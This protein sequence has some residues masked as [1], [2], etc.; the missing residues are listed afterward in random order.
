MAGKNIVIVTASIGSG[1]NKA[2][3]ALEESLK[4]NYPNSNVHI[5]DFVANDTGYI[6]TFVK[7]IYL[8]LLGYTPN[9]YDFFY[10]FTSST[11]RGKTV[12]SIFSICMKQEMKEIIKRYNADMIICTHPF[13]CGAANLLKASGQMD[14]PLIAII[15]D[16]A[17][18][19]F[20]YHKAVDLY[21]VANDNIK[22]DL[23]RRNIDEDKIFVTG[24]PISIDFVEK[25]DKNKIREKLNLKVD[26][27]TVLIMGGGLGLGNVINALEEIERVKQQLQIL[28]VTG[29]NV[30]LWSEVNEY[31]KGSK[32]IIKVWGYSHNIKE[33]MYAADM[34]LSKP[35][36]LTIS[37]ALVSNTPMIL[38]NPIPGPEYENA[39]YTFENNAAIW[40]KHEETLA[41]VITELIRDK[42][43]I[44]RLKKSS[45]KLAKPYAAEE[46]IEIIHE[47][48][49]DIL[50]G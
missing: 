5:V 6:N 12:Q 42:T 9:I 48:Y 17:F 25:L 3:L 11:F 19:Q 47:K 31:I 26:L 41:A 21:F 37:E 27:P 45:Q 15:T 35:G 32:H 36:A 14:I 38:H 46:I 28:V 18:H 2:S 30:S 50:K 39:K 16:F 22:K 20:W 33:L 43:I 34:L 49:P 40:I 7:D 44:S 8:K 4:K 29:A 24:I 1:H 13:P 23:A 10:K